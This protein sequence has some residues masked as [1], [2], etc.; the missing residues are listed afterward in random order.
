M[1]DLHYNL[2]QPFFKDSLGIFMRSEKKIVTELQKSVYILPCVVHQRTLNQTPERS[3][4][5][6]RSLGEQRPQKK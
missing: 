4:H 5:M 3:P 2:L 6:L 1:Y